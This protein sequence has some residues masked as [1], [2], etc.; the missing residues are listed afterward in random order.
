MPARPLSSD[1]LPARLEHGPVDAYL[2]AAIDGDARSIE[3]LTELGS[4]QLRCACLQLAA[5]V[6]AQQSLIEWL[7][8]RG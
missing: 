1:L 6:R 3:Y 2:G 5:I 7:G 8:R 4:D